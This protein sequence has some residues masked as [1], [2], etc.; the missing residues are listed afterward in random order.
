MQ[1]NIQLSRG[2]LTLSNN[3]TDDD[4]IF[5]RG[6]VNTTR[7]VVHFFEDGFVEFDVLDF[8]A[9][10]ELESTLTPAQQLRFRIPFPNITLTPWQVCCL[11]SRTRLVSGTDKHD[12][13][14]MLP[15]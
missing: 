6:I 5:K 13:F 4:N 12:R 14:Q 3:D 7:E 1:G 11:P 8:A 9:H 15:L 2:T 10:I